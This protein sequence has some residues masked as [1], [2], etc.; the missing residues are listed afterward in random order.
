MASST[1]G[2][3][4]GANGGIIHWDGSA[5]SSQ[6]NPAQG[7]LQ[8]VGVVSNVDIWAG[9]DDGQL[10]HGDGARWAF[11]AGAIP[12][13]AL[14]S[15]DMASADDGWAVGDGILHWDGTVWR[16]VNTP[17]GVYLEGV[18]A[19]S[20]TDAWA[21]GN[22]IVH[23]DGAA[24]S[25]VDSPTSEWL[26]DVDIVSVDDGWA[27]GGLNDDAPCV[28]LHWDGIAWSEVTCP[29]EF[30]LNAVAMVASD[31]GWAVGGEYYAGAQP[32][33]LRWDGV[34]WSEFPAPNVDRGLLA[35]SMASA[36]DGWAVGG[37]GITLHWDGQAWRQ[38]ANPFPQNLVSV[39]VATPP[40]VWALG[41]DE[42]S[43]TYSVLY[44]KGRTWVSVPTP[45]AER[46]LWAL[47]MVGDDG[48]ALGY[49]GT[50]LRYSPFPPIYRIY[51]PG[52]VV[53][54][55]VGT[56]ADAAASGGRP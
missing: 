15:V 12:N 11:P 55:T 44:G 18:D 35:I 52:V 50:I 1:D 53:Q 22:Q 48:W 21:V 25:L 3:A 46:S 33:I 37:G 42:G 8:A 26:S 40:H 56:Q 39:S 4:V 27:V 38:V 32:I 24:W 45:P 54:R 20:S 49:G 34:V 30:G 2:W 19:V 23:W 29:V 51:L 36:S 43:G 31:D 13:V 7:N 14:R 28:I 5:W 9:G 6:P 10:L 17:S 41:G 16:P 47:A